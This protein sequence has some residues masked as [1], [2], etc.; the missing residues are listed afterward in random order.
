MLWILSGNSSTPLSFLSLI[1][2]LKK[3]QIP[4][5]DA[6]IGCKRKSILEIQQVLYCGNKSGGGAKQENEQVVHL[7]D[8]L[9][10]VSWKAHV[11]D[12]TRHTQAFF[13]RSDECNTVQSVVVVGNSST[14]SDSSSLT[15]IVYLADSW[16]HL[17]VCEDTE[18]CIASF[19][20]RKENGLPFSGELSGAHGFIFPGGVP[21]EEDKRR[22]VVMGELRSMKSGALSEYEV[23]VQARNLLFVRIVFFLNFFTD[24][25]SAS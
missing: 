14:K 10:R 1:Q 5:Q 19:C 13:D 11:F 22:A 4:S 16:V 7:Q 18:E 6:V 2:L 23:I 8:M 3:S 21:T 12:P 25:L 20:A 17:D 15:G 24:S 9:W